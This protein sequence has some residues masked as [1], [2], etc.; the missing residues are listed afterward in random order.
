MVKND[1][2]HSLISG[3]AGFILGALDFANT[4]GVNE[5]YEY[6]IYA[7]DLLLQQADLNTEMYPPHQPHL[8]RLALC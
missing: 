5:Y 6:A 2:F 1:I 3:N 8:F 7:G 4:Y